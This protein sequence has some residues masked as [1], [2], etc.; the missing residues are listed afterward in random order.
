MICARPSFGWMLSHCLSGSLFASFFACLFCR[1]PRF[2]FGG[3]SSCSGLGRSSARKMVKRRGASSKSSS[4][5]GEA[6]VYLALF[7]R[8]FD[9]RRTRTSA[10]RRLLHPLFTSG[11]FCVLSSF[12][13]SSFSI[14]LPATAATA[15][16]A[17]RTT[18]ASPGPGRHSRAEDGRNAKG[19]ASIS[20]C[21]VI[22]HCN[23]DV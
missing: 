16:A 6:K 4:N 15:A 21:L 13:F 17:A 20:V 18:A 1:W 11:Y 2:D 12:L 14:I 5:S 22:V 3:D 23:A 7:R 19:N 10:R 9:E 8:G